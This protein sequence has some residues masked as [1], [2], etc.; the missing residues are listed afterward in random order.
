MDRIVNAIPSYL[1][2]PIIIV[3]FL[4]L[5]ALI[6]KSLREGR[7]IS[8]WPPRIGPRPTSQEVI[9][10]KPPASETQLSAEKEPPR[11]PLAE[12]KPLPS[13]SVEQ[14][15]DDEPLPSLPL[16]VRRVTPL[17]ESQQRPEN[18]LEEV[19]DSYRQQ[20]LER[21]TD[22]S[23]L[24]RPITDLNINSIRV[25]EVI[26][27]SK[28]SR[29][30][31]CFLKGTSYV[32]KRTLEKYCQIE[33]LTRIAG[34]KFEGYENSITTLVAAPLAVWQKDD[35][36][37]ELHPFYEGMTLHELVVS[38]KHCIQGSLLGSIYN[39]M[40]N[41]VSALHKEGVLHRDI[42]PTNILI[43]PAGD[44]VILDCS[45]C[46]LEDSEQIPVGNSAYTSQE[47]RAGSACNASDWFSIAGTTYFLANGYAPDRR[48]AQRFSEGL[49]RIDTGEF[50]AY[51]G[52][53]PPTSSRG[54]S[55]PDFFNL[56]LNP[57]ASDRPSDLWR[58]CLAHSSVAQGY[59]SSVIGVLDMGRSGIIL[60]QECDFQILPRN[61][62]A[63]FLQEAVVYDAISPDILND[64][65]AIIANE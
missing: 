43:T 17:L 16:R 4:L 60:T 42:A 27:E 9:K 61:K 29:V 46:C 41:A 48:N 52:F 49:M 55:M 5:V 56:L 65:N 11:P 23:S 64:A 15:R 14:K 32:L 28:Y 59:F 31:K 62:V 57:T 47:Q 12:Q 18:R 25:A 51:P 36:V 19:L 54:W 22:Q 30:E 1:L 53:K 20:R 6:W 33:A 39:S 26:T 10:E 21:K 50:R 24:L 35:Y 2:I 45:F 44:L 7:E 63:E 58:I 13:L 8:F 37:Y 40:L 34:K 3:G 38:N